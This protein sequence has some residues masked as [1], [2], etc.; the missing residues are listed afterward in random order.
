MADMLVVGE[1][2]LVE[3]G[4]VQRGDQLVVVSGTRAA[5][6]GGTN[7]LKVMTVGELD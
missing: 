6:R 4:L 3:S 2:L 7:T 5:N 1:R